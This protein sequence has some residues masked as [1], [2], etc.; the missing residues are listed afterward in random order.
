[1]K[2]IITT[3]TSYHTLAL[4]PHVDIWWQWSQRQEN[5]SIQLGWLKWCLSIEMMDDQSYEEFKEL[6]ID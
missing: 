6:Y 3:V 2:A 4:L 5:I 1:M